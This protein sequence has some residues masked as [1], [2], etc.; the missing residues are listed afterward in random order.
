[1][2]HMLNWILLFISTTILFLFQGLL[3]LIF[4]KQKINWGKCIIF[5]MIN[6]L[7]REVLHVILPQYSSSINLVIYILVM[8]ATLNLVLKVKLLHSIFSTFTLILFSG[9]VDYI[10]I[11]ILKVSLQ[12]SFNIV[13]WVESS[14]YT[15]YLRMSCNI[16]W[17]IAVLVMYNSKIGIEVSENISTKKYMSIL[18]NGLITA[19]VII[20]N[21]LFFEHSE[22]K[23]PVEIFVF[24]AASLLLLLSLHI[25]NSI[26]SNELELKKQEV[27]FQ[28][29]YI[30]TLD[31]VI[32]GLRGFKHD[33]NNLIQVFGGYIA[34]DDLKGLKKYYNQIQNEC[35]TI[36]NKI[37]LN[38]YVKDN[39][40]IYG[41]LLSKISYSEIMDISFN[42]IINDN[43]N[44]RDIKILDFCK[45]L[46]ILLDNALE[47]AANS[48]KRYV[49]L[50]VSESLQNDCL[51][52][53]IC[54][55]FS[56]K[57]E[58]EKMFENGYTTKSGHSGFGL[59]EVSKILSKYKHCTM[60]T[61]V[62][63]GLFTQLIEIRN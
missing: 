18:A 52:I 31:D 10:V 61:S 32:D 8:A 57:V 49:E 45:V 15:F 63:D 39:P 48:E 53:A 2:Y 29:L 24:N 17:L 12:S 1:M 33:F 20:P 23:V 34:L 25:Y 6:A 11:A 27:E 22:I 5:A 21:V 19:M 51:K 42:V 62:S 46:G 38:S 60:K 50:S 4:F 44:L 14:K 54:N 47:A 35:R 28:K 30:N 55:T 58:V 56:G 7:F 37:P 43:M 3:I 16:V 9:A 13:E 40:A 59:W 26:R 36:N 41:I